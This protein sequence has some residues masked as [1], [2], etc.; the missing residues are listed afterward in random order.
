MLFPSAGAAN[1][2]PAYRVRPVTAVRKKGP[3]RRFSASCGR[4]WAVFSAPGPKKWPGVACWG[5]GWRCPQHVASTPCPREEYLLAPFSPLA[6]STTYAGLLFVSSIAVGPWCV[7]ESLW[8]HVHFDLLD[9]SG[10]NNL[11]MF[12]ICFFC[13]LFLHLNRLASWV[14]SC[15]MFTH[16]QERAPLKLN[17]R[18]R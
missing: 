6:T 15:R 12:T 17:F 2:S 8:A 11:P 14:A 1:G 16:S 13:C 18:A 7:S 5:R 10:N 4:D 3:N 9:A